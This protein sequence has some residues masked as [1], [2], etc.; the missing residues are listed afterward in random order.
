MPIP[1]RP[2]LLTVD[3]RPILVVRLLR[4]LSTLSLCPRASARGR[5]T[6]RAEMRT[7]KRSSTTCERRNRNKSMMGRA[8]GLWRLRTENMSYQGYYINLDR[9]PERKAQ[10]E[11]QLHQLNPRQRYRRFPAVEGASCGI[12]SKNLKPG[13]VGCFLSHYRLLEQHLSQPLNLH[14]M[15]DDVLLS[16]YAAGMLEAMVAKNFFDKFDLIYTDVFVPIDVE[17]IASYKR[18]YDQCLQVEASGARSFR[19]FQVLDLSNVNFA[20]TA[21]YLINGASIPKVSGLLRSHLD[22]GI[23]LPVDI[24][25]R[26]LVHEGKLHA[27][28]LFPFVTSVRPES[29]VR[30]QIDGRYRSSLSVLVSFLVR[31]SFFVDCDWEKCLSLIP[32]DAICDDSDPHRKTIMSALKFRLFGDFQLF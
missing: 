30:T 25:L 2:E 27:A 13:E 7:Q 24:L 19:N 10:V 28:C 32:P 21:S 17:L 29:Q 3:A 23:C 31:Y 6:G 15:E 26:N 14:V 18:I 11:S 1:R 22:S 4:L 16:K 9:N 8:I 12:N 20:V 5:L